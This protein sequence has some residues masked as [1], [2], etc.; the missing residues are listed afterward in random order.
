MSPITVAIISF[1]ISIISIGISIYNL[2]MTKK[3]LLFNN[4]LEIINYFKEGSLLTE[5]DRKSWNLLVDSL[6]TS[7]SCEF[8][9]TGSIDLPT[10]LLNSKDY[11]IELE[12]DSLS[13]NDLLYGP[14]PFNDLNASKSI[15]NVL[16][17]LDYISLEVLNKNVSERL[18]YESLKG[19]YCMALFIIQSIN[20]SAKEDYVNI[21]KLTKKISK[22]D[23]LSFKIVS[24]NSI[25]S[26][27][28][29]RV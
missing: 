28:Y 2:L 7:N 22:Y 15:L 1:I 8:I 17:M 20:A 23:S 27:Y 6:E 26:L 24:K 3:S 29:F 19:F 12:N 4:A 10:F 9:L 25:N 11:V 16:N 5:S 21:I 14:E 18:V 13:I